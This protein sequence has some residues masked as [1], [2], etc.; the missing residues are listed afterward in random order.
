[1]HTTKSFEFPTLQHAW[2]GLNEYLANNQPEI[3]SLGGG[4]YG[5][6][7][8]LYNVLVSAS[9]AWID[10]KF[11]FGH[12]LGYTNKK[13]TK[14]VNNYVDFDYLDLVKAEVL[15][16]ERRKSRNY[17]HTMHFSNTHGSGKDCLISLTF[18]R[19][20]NSDIPVV[21]YHTRATECTKRMIFD[22]LLIQKI[23]E[24]VYGVDKTVEVKMFIPFMFIAVEGFLLFHNYKPL[25]E[26][27]HC[28]HTPSTANQFQGRI[29]KAYHKFMDIDL[30]KIRYKVHKRSAMGIQRNADGSPAHNRKGL[31]A[32]DMPLMHKPQLRKVKDIDKLNQ[33][34]R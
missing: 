5:T 30:E 14:L 2:A 20:I 19:S 27:L 26:S 7:M 3:E 10:P 9:K 8:C 11:D 22:F 28:W 31:F 29:Y 25:E 13:W 1:M 33:S 16:R 23:V 18:C 15:D 32:K 17:T 12:V 6:E 21:V 34:K 4:I 24:Y